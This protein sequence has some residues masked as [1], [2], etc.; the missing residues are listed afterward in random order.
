MVFWQ[1]AIGLPLLLT[2]Y[3][4]VLGVLAR[5]REMPFTELPRLSELLGSS[6]VLS[7]PPTAW[8][9]LLFNIVCNAAATSALLRLVGATNSL[10]A[11]LGVTLYR[12]GAILVSALILN[13]PPF[14]PPLMGL[15]CVL[16]L[17]GSL[18]YLRASQRAALAARSAARVSYSK[19]S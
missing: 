13:A 16:V 10:V 5:W 17:C 6:M 19:R 18:A 7:A 9:L 4:A 1:H 15:G 2:E 12:F 8:L 3:P 14:P 11:S